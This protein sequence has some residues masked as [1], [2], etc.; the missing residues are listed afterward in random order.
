MFRD[1]VEPRSDAVTSKG[2]AAPSW[3]RALFGCSNPWIYTTRLDI[4]TL[5]E[6]PCCSDRI[7]EGTHAMTMTPSEPC[8]QIQWTTEII[9]VW[10]WPLLD[11]STGSFQFSLLFN[12]NGAMVCIGPLHLLTNDGQLSNLIVLPDPKKKLKNTMES[13]GSPQ[14]NITTNCIVSQT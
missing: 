11:I 13:S 6:F 1:T 8:I 12:K 3:A 9:F 5:A 10:V 2:V 7:F 14:V 4:Q